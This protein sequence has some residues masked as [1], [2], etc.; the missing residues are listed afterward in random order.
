[1][2]RLLAALAG[3]AILAACAR[4]DA[5][6]PAQDASASP[7]PAIVGVWQGTVRDRSGGAGTQIWR[8]ELNPD[9]TYRSTTRFLQGGTV[10]HW[11][12]YVVA[13]G[14]LRMRLMGW[15]PRQECGPSGCFPLYLP[16]DDTVIVTQI[17]PQQI[18]TEQGA[19]ARVQ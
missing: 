19:L 8:L 6:S 11:G 1:M 17:A 13:D 4:Q 12:R 7:P 10:Q 3:L 16:D 15:E 14:A 5:V 18:V 9:G 2:H